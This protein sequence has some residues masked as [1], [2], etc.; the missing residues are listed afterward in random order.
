VDLLRVCSRCVLR[1]E[2][3]EKEWPYSFRLVLVSGVA[4][5]LE[6]G[7]VGMISS[8][9]GCTSGTRRTGRTCPQNE[10]WFLGPTRPQNGRR[11]RNRLY[12]EQGRFVEGQHVSEIELCELIGK[13]SF[14]IGFGGV[15]DAGEGVGVCFCAIRK[16]YVNICR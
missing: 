8:S 13:S 2:A 12:A 16:K 14:E 11:G 7:G 6:Y 4:T 9:T 15:G 10:T 1:L 5:K 3:K